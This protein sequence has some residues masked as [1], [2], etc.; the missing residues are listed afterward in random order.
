MLKDVIYFVAVL[1]IIFLLYNIVQNMNVISTTE[2]TYVGSTQR[3]GV[4]SWLGS[5]LGWFGS[6]SND[7][8]GTDLGSGIGGTQ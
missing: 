2:T 7:N 4:V 8:S 3:P 6:G 5:V 1:G